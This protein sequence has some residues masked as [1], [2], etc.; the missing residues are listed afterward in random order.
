MK[1]LNTTIEPVIEIILSPKQVIESVILNYIK[2]D[3]YMTIENACGYTIFN[4]K[5]SNMI[6]AIDKINKFLGI[7]SYGS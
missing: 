7:G 5:E 3:K 1:E 6:I 2:Q 4:I